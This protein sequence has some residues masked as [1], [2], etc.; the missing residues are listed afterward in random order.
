MLNRSGLSNTLGASD[1]IQASNLCMGINSK[2]V[3]IEIIGIP[4]ITHLSTAGVLGASGRQE[5][6]HRRYS[7]YRH[8]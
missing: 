3:S 7:V 5:D 2:L 4:D 1:V 6:P 8:E